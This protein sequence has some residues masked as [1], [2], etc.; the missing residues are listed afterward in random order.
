M[1]DATAHSQDDALLQIGEVAERT[2]LS[3]RTVRYYEEMGLVV[4]QTR[5]AGGF[6]LFRQEHVDRLELIK[7]MKPLGFSVQEM[8]EVLDA[9]DTL[10]TP[11]DASSESEARDALADFA[12]VAGERYA[13]R[14][15]QLAGAAGLAERLRLDSGARSSGS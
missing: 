1:P 11:A 2:G 10:R 9:Y 7:Q 8:R 14:Q 4:P 6:R 5:T 15:R 3:L 12:K 13:K